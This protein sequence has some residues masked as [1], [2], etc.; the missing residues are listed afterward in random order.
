MTAMT[1]T[2]PALPAPLP[3]RVGPLRAVP[4][5]GSLA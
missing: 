4:Q 3:A 2:A 5:T 1:A